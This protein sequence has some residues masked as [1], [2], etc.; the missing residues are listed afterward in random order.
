MKVHDLRR[1]REF[2]I[3]AWF[4]TSLSRRLGVIVCWRR[5]RRGKKHSALVLFEAGRPR[6]LHPDVRVQLEYAGGLRSG[7]VALPK[8]W[9]S[10]AGA[11]GK[12]LEVDSVF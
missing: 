10:G 8:R 9:W 1:L 4:R 5:S 2:P 7:R 3:L 11:A 12:T 6:E